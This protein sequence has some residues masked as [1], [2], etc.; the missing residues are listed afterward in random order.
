MGPGHLLRTRALFLA[1]VLGVSACGG[2]GFD[3][4]Q[5]VTDVVGTWDVGRGVAAC[6]IDQLVSEVGEDRLADSRE[7]TTAEVELLNTVRSPC[8]LREQWIALIIET[9]GDRSTAACIFDTAVDEFGAE[10]VTGG[11][12]D[13]AQTARL[14]QITEDCGRNES[15]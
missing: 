11:E 8:E 3:R 2:G 10:T 9:A 5:A 1:V 4:T 12:A 6:M 13:E 14:A 7:P 15:S